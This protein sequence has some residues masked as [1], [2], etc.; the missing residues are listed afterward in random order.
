MTNN[1]SYNS[2]H[3][4]LHNSLHKIVSFLGGKKEYFQ[5][6]GGNVS[7]KLDG[8]NNDS[9]DNTEMTIKASGVRVSEMTQPE[10][11]V[12]VA[13]PDIRAYFKNTTDGLDSK[14]EDSISIIKKSVLSNNND[15]NRRPSM[16]TGFHALLGNVVLHTHSVYV[17]L[18][19]CSETF[20]DLVNELFPTSSGGKVTYSTI[21]YATPGHFLTHKVKG[22]I[23]K[24]EQNSAGKNEVI[25]HAIFMKNH[26]IIVSA[27]TADE[28]ITIHEEIN[29]KIIDHFNILE[30]FP[31]S[32]PLA[33]QSDG[34]ESTNLFLK[35]FAMNRPEIFSNIPDFLLFPDL[36]VFC[37]DMKVTT[38]NDPA[39]K[40]VVNPETG[41]ITYNTNIKEAEFIEENLLAWAHLMKMIPTLKLTPQYISDANSKAIEN[42]DSEK[43][44]KK[45]VA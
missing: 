15:D 27:E 44:R 14:E 40:I 4:P 17:N 30:L 7:I 38:D 39:A 13:Y 12:A 33:M 16:E 22:V 36:V 23:S 26:G 11:V 45:L 34:L 21:G 19:T 37:K 5:G 2:S 35:Q 24:V 31:T 6:A 9:A 25:A 32:S 18:L 41:D 8:S 43:Y 10:G 1:S 29:Q 28:A 42:M 3:N 20:E